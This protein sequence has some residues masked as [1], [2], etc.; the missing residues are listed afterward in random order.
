MDVNILSIGSHMHEYGTEFRVDHI[1]TDGRIDNVYAIDPDPEYRNF[2]V[3]LNYEDGGIAVKAGD[4]FL[5]SCKGT[6]PPTKRFG[7]PT[8]CALR[9]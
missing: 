6:I 7:S 8:R 1:H 3:M 2:P 9:L 4:A 5:T